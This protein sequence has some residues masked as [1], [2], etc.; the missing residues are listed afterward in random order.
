VE[1][2]HVLAL[3]NCFFCLT[4]RLDSP[5]NSSLATH[6]YMLAHMQRHGFAAGQYKENARGNYVIKLGA[7][8]I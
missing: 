2:S 4:L 7:C 5:S 1:N 6:S 3:T 8:A